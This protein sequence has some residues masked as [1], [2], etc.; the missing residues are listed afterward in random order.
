MIWSGR[1]FFN[2]V[3]NVLSSRTT[4]QTSRTL[5]HW[6]LIWQKAFSESPEWV[7]E[8]R[9]AQQLLLPT[10]VIESFLWGWA[11]TSGRGA[12]K[13]QE[14]SFEF[15]F[16]IRSKFSSFISECIAF[17]EKCGTLDPNLPKVFVQKWL[18]KE[19]F[20]LPHGRL[21]SC[22][23]VWKEG[24]LSIFS[25]CYPASRL[26]MNIWQQQLIFSQNPEIVDVVVVHYPIPSQATDVP[27]LL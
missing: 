7:H 8:L 13:V 5:V 2:Q 20:L 15:S 6:L 23:T 27:I 11:T 24:L 21:C 1:N 10:T 17:L 12:S 16:T 19:T 3:K 25:D 14:T 22:H 26:L 18:R 4:F 9:E